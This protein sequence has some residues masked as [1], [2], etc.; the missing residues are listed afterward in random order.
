MLSARTL[1]LIEKLQNAPLFSFVGHKISDANVARADT[2][3]QTAKLALSKLWYNVRLEQQN[4]LTSELCK[5]H[6]KRY[7]HWNRIVAEVNPLLMPTVDAA[8]ERIKP[9]IKL[10]PR[11][12]AEFVV[13]VRVDMR[14]AC[15]ETQ[16]SDIS[17]QR[18]YQTLT[19][20]YLRGHFPCGWTGK[21]QSGR[22][23]VF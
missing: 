2:W 17:S 11:A 22:L 15:S 16:Y 20:W 21:Y 9:A 23:I 3:R 19:G 5:W 12:W 13:S 10:Q 8:L 14:G 7:E 18:F 4:D 1:S 6:R